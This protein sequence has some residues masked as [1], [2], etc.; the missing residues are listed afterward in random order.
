MSD[1]NGGMTDLDDMKDMEMIMQQLLYEQSLQ[2]QEAE[3]SNRRNYI[4]RE[5]DVAEEHLM[6]DYF[7]DH[8]KYPA[9]YFKKRG[10]CFEP[11]RTDQ[12]ITSRALVMT[13]GLNLP[14]Q[15]LNAQAEARK[16]ENIKSEDLGGMIEK[17]LESRADGTLCLKNKSW[18]PC[19]GDLRA[20]IIH[21]SHK[22]KYSI[23]PGFD[24]MYQ[25]L[26]KLYWWPN[27]KADIATYVSKCLTCSKVKAEHQKPSGLL[28]QPVI[29]Q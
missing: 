21:E 11:K 2:E 17:K 5:R 3:S 15:I 4:Y 29:P 10:R 14:V 13:I 25:D 28:V 27:M 7:V 16:A 9:Y 23:H 1:S 20:L 12:T 18:L 22:S 19:F 26:K 24:K 8:Q 6:A